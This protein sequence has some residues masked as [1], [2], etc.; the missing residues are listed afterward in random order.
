MGTLAEGGGGGG[1]GFKGENALAAE[2]M[3]DEDGGSTRAGILW[4]STLMYEPKDES[5]DL[6]LTSFPCWEKSGGQSKRTLGMGRRRCWWCS[7][8]SVME[9][10]GITLTDGKRRWWCGRECWWR[11]RGDAAAAVAV[12]EWEWSCM[13]L[14]NMVSPG[15]GWDLCFTRGGGGGCRWCGDGEDEVGTIIKGSLLAPP[16]YSGDPS[17]WY[18]MSGLFG[19]DFTTIGL[20]SPSSTSRPSVVRSIPFSR[21]SWRFRRNR[22]RLLDDGGEIAAV[23]EAEVEAGAED[24]V[25]PADWALDRTRLNGG[26]ARVNADEVVVVVV[27]V[28]ATAAVDTEVMRMSSWLWFM[29]WLDPDDSM[30]WWKMY[31]TPYDNS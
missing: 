27:A 9:A 14:L 20:L 18:P 5:V 23:A 31:I 21:Q 25:S 15:R 7:A 28:A 3:V 6:D 16:L 11:R 2:V 30:C 13:G 24:E 4:W 19:D 22:L 29:L 10:S 12:A 1:G 8:I 17:P 26:M